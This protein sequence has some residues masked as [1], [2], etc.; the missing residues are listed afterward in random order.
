MIIEESIK[1]QID[2]FNGENVFLS[3]FYPAPIT[4]GALQFPT[5][6]HAFHAEKTF[7]QQMKWL[8]AQ[9]RSPGQAKKLGRKLDLRADWEDIKFSVMLNLVRLKF[10]DFT[11]QAKLLATGES[12]LI[13]GNNWGDTYWGIC[14]SEGQNNLGKI[15]MKVREEIWQN[16]TQ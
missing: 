13:E 15:L 3:N 9:A 16:S 4:I 7:D 1:K 8:I 2:H 11:L 10:E 14:N 6:E 5:V 12:E